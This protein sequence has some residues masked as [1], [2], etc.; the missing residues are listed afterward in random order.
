MT[1]VPTLAYLSLG[2]L[3]RLCTDASRQ[4]LGFVL[5]QLS[6]TDQWS[7]VQAGSHFL[8]LAESQYAVIELELLVIA[9]V[10]A[11]LHMLLGGL[12]HFTVVTDHNPLIPIHPEQPLSRRN[13]EPSTTAPPHLFDGLKFYGCLV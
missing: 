1:E 4:G 7:L 3:T 6:S 9:W 8:T 10:V 5:Q 13:S 12:Q 11:K 2:K